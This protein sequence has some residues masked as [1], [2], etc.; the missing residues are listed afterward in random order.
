MDL[1]LMNLDGSN[2]TRMTFF[3]EPGHEESQTTRAVVGDLSWSPNGDRIA[4]V[5][6]TIADGGGWT[7]ESWILTFE[8][9][10]CR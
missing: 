6:T 8:L 3:N 10:G 2:T 1:W 5:V 4:M 9:Y 7:E